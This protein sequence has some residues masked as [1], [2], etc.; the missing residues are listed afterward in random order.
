MLPKYPPKGASCGTWFERQGRRAGYQIIAGVDEVGR[1]ALFGPV[2]AAAV[3]LDPCKRIRGIQDSKRLSARER[4]RLSDVIRRRALAWSI[5]SVDSEQ[6]DRINI[7]QAS[8][9][10]M[11]QAV[12]EL[13]PPAELVLVDALRLDIQQAQL[14]IIHGD[15]L[16]ISIAAASILAKVERDRL[17]GEWDRI[18][19]HYQLARNKGYATAAHRAM[20]RELGPTPLHRNSYAPVAESRQGPHGQK[21]RDQSESLIPVET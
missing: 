21:A 8:R 3:I 2:L 15:A 11:R 6:I 9:L 5:A 19:P 7:Y 16:S 14:P 17:M 12:L 10:A 20:L 1:G 18:Y 13:N 4:E